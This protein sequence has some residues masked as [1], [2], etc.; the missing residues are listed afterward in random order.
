[1]KKAKKD[2]LPT[3]PEYD[4]SK[5]IKNPYA[6]RMRQFGSNLVVIEPDLYAIFPNGEAVNDALRMLA[7][8]S[9]KA[10]RAKADKQIAKAS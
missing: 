5:A 10:A 7:R 6:D 4:F 8:I 9:A 2:Q 3:R 1:M